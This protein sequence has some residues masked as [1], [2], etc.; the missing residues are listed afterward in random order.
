MFH[1]D[2]SNVKR[3][4]TYL[5]YILL[6]IKSSKELEF[7]KNLDKEGSATQ[8]HIS[9]NQAKI[10]RALFINLCA[11]SIPTIRCLLRPLHWFTL[12]TNKILI[13]LQ[14]ATKA[15]Q[16]SLRRT[17]DNKVKL[18]DTAVLST[19]LVAPEFPV[20]GSAK[21]R[22]TNL[23]LQAAA[24]SF[25]NNILLQYPHEHFLWSDGAYRRSNAHS[26]AATV[27]TI[28]DNIHLSHHSYSVKISFH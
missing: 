19:Q 28:D 2:G 16:L 18:Y 13:D 23:S 20:F 25:I 5:L 8:S 27:V 15:K 1:I 4:F 7:Y 12:S 24:T 10:I 17:I 11:I 22:R 3:C 9:V 26:S 14:D 21:L 6:N